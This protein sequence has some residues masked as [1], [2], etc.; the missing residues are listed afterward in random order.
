MWSGV[1]FFDFFFFF[2]AEDG[3]RDGHV[4]GVQTCAL[5]IYGGLKLTELRDVRQQRAKPG[6]VILEVAYERGGVARVLGEPVGQIGRA[7][8][9]ERVWGSGGG[10]ALEKKNVEQRGRAGD[11][12]G[13]P[14]T[15]T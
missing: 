11:A 4:T 14:L 9:R 13:L 15:R 2:Q 12:R 7:S 3:I 5:P 8:C 1:D 10:G 6:L